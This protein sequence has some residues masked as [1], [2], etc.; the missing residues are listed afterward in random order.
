M[1]EFFHCFYEKLKDLDIENQYKTRALFLATYSTYEG[2][3]LTDT[4]CSKLPMTKKE[5]KI[6]LKISQSEFSRTI[7][8]LKESNLILE[9]DI[10]YKINTEFIIKGSV[11]GEV[12]IKYTRV[13]IKGLQTLYYRSTPISHK[14]LYI[15]F[16]LLPNINLQHNIICVNP[17]EEEVEL[18]NPFSLGDICEKCGYNANQKSRVWKSLLELKI[19]SQ[20]AICKTIRKDLEII[21]VNPKLYYGGTRLE[22]LR[23]LIGIFN[24]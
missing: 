12:D 10:G 16:S 6:R 22:D 3:C 7:T 15:L 13:F 18:I 5:V 8:A 4:S 19:G 1:G 23:F 11:S 9:D 24:M 2:G 17:E 21:C 20:F 14:K